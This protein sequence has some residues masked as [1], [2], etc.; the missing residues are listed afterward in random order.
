MGC[1]IVVC[2]CD[3]YAEIW[4]KNVSLWWLF[5]ISKILGLLV[6]LYAVFVDLEL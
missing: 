4:G 6:W 2:V 3:F 5:K 1:F